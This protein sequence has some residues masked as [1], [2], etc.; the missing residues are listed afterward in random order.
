MDGVRF[1]VII[2]TEKVPQPSINSTS[3]FQQIHLESNL[4]RRKA[5]VSRTSG[6]SPYAFGTRIHGRA[7]TQIG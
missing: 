7:S 1:D 2:S 6:G 5:A 3:E 4:F